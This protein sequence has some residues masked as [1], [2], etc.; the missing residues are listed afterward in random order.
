MERVVALAV[1]EVLQSGSSSLFLHSCA[2]VS[3]QD[4]FRAGSLGAA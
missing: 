4:G 2:L 3:E 1:L